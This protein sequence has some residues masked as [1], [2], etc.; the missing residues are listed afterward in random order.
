M[1]IAC[2]NRASVLQRLHR[3]ADALASCDRAL[4]LDGN[5]AEAHCN[6]GSIL[7]Q[8][9]RHDA[10]LA[11]LDRAIS[12]KPDLVEAHANRGSVLF[13]LERYGEALASRER[14]IALKP[15]LPYAVGDWLYAKMYCCNWSDFDVACQRLLA[16]MDRGDRVATPYVALLIDSTPEQ[17]QRCARSYT[18]DQYPARATSLPRHERKRGDR[19]RIGYVSAAFR[20]TPGAHLMVAP[21]RMP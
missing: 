14:V 1:R 19:I 18:A 9:Q 13:R 4:A 2:S 6:R 3:L 21:L 10:A 20:N 11:S 7:N 8:M 17:Q 16:G 15:D 12:L 5:L